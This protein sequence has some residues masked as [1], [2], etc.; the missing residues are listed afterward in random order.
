[1]SFKPA[2]KMWERI[3]VARDDSDTTLFLHLLYL[4]EM[5]TKTVAAGLV[6]AILDDRDR[7]RYRQLH[8]LVRADSL[9]EWCAVIGDVLVGPASQHLLLGAYDE[10]RDLSQKCGAG[11]WQHDA[12]T[13]LNDCAKL[14]SPTCESLPTKL[15]GA[16]WFSTFARLRNDTR[17]HGAVQSKLC[18]QMCPKVEMSIRLILENFRLFKRPWAYLH[19]NLSGKYRVT[20]LTE[21]ADTFTPLKSTK[22]VNLPDGVYVDFDHHCLVSLIES[23]VDAD[24]FFFPNGGFNDKRFELISYISGNKAESDAAPYLKPASELP[25]SETQGIGQ[26]VV[27]EKCFGNLPPIPNGYVQRESLESELHAILID[28]RHPVVTLV[29]RGGIGKTSLALYALHNLTKTDRFAT[30]VWFSSRDIDL[31]PQGPKLVKP[32]V[33]T[34]NDMAQ[35]F[36]LLMEPQ[37]RGQKGFKALTYFQDA[38]QKGPAGPTLFIFDNFETVRSPASVFKWLDTYIRLPN[39]ALITT[40]H[41]DFKGDYYLEVPGMTEDEC[42]ELV[43]RVSEAL[44][45]T[46]LVT[47]DYRRRLYAESDGHPYV[48]KIL[49]GEVAKAGRIG[50]PERIVA[51]KDE[52][53]D[54][55]FERTFSGLSP[56]AKRVFLTLCNWRSSVPSLALEAVLLRPVNEEMD[57]KAAIEELRQSSFVE[58]T[59]S[60]E[61]GAEFLSVPLA[62]SVF[63]NPKLKVSKMKSAIEADTEFLHDFGA[64]GS[65]DIRHGIRPRIERMFGHVARRVSESKEQLD[66]YLPMLKFISRKYPPAW[67]LLASLYEESSSN[68]DLELAKESLLSYLELGGEAIDREHAWKRVAVLCRRTEDWVGEAHA[69]LEMSQ[70]PGAPFKTISDAANSLNILISQPNVGLDTYEKEILVRRVATVMDSRIEEGDATD[71]SRLA[72]LCLR[73]REDDRAKQLTERGLKLDPRNEYI[74]KLATRLSIL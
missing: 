21:D 19:R 48:I 2:D 26:L 67:L 69:F 50:K 56:V 64:V 17:G 42:D 13:L 68:L 5:L 30:I 47:E 18:G 14:V 52:I 58:V 54:A 32:H 73:L 37:E 36:V 33:L 4:G 34:E 24:D 35:E 7:H 62:A 9:G 40:R 44:G 22:S 10:Q 53:L 1:M 25:T 23:S 15:D 20:P 12:V 59:V 6:S 49:L 63:G 31:L 8:R 55:L 28:D 70:L 66:Y 61:D 43:N 16:S 57:V 60:E 29:G 38:L 27:Q 51:S 71:C 45:I 46:N 74:Y 11:T 72:W 39:K 3:E 65:S 41:R